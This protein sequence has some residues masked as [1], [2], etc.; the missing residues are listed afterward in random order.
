MAT[1]AQAEHELTSS[2]GAVS[3]PYAPV[4]VE[5]PIPAGASAVDVAVNGLGGREL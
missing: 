1:R 3:S 4:I 2:I 5:D